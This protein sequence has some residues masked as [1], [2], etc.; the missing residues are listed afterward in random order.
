MSNPTPCGFEQRRGRLAAVKTQRRAAGPGGRPSGPARR[1][2]SSSAKRLRSSSAQPARSEPKRP[3][4]ERKNPEPQHALAAVAR[5][6]SA[7]PTGRAAG[8]VSQNAL[9]QGQLIL[10]PAPAVSNE[11]RGVLPSWPWRRLFL[12]ARWNRLEVVKTRKKRENTG[13]KWAR[14]GLKRVN[15]ERT[16]G[17]NWCNKSRSF[18]KK[19]FEQAGISRDHQRSMAAMPAAK[20]PRPSYSTGPVAQGRVRANAP[21]AFNFQETNRRVRLTLRSLCGT[22]ERRDWWRRLDRG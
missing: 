3:S 15:K 21:V 18:L 14:Y 17:I 1:L 6:E 22:E 12:G 20:R 5:R 16:G 8:P 13:G 10:P 4:S 7:Y 9:Q 11:G 2:R 19:R